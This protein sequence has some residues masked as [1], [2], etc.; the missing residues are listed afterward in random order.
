MASREF[1]ADRTAAAASGSITAGYDAELR[2]YEELNAFLAPEL[3]KRSFRVRCRE[4]RSVKD[5]VESVGVPH[6]EVDLILVDGVSVGFDFRLDRG[7]RV[8]VYPVFETLDIS[9]VSK[10]GRPPLR[11]LRFVADV[12]LGKLVRRLR[13]LGFDCRYNPAWTD[14]DLARCSAAEER[15][16]LTRDRNLLKRA[17][18]T[19]GMFVHAHQPETQVREVVQHLQLRD[20]ARPFGRCARCNGLLAPVSKRNVRKRVPVRTYR[21]VHRYVE[22]GRCGQVYWKGTHWQRLRRIVA[23]ALDRN[24]GAETAPD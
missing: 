4:P 14:E 20:V 2:F 18:V 8:S 23:H 9:S 1:D 19:H 5:L 6:T 13:L 16:L 22:C 24:P 10:L 17:L 21:H 7:C 11:V 12:H 15:I 3:R